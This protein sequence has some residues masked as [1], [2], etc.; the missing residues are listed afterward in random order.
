MSQTIYGT[1]MHWSNLRKP[2]LLSALFN[3]LAQGVF[4]LFIS[5]SSVDKIRG[6]ATSYSNLF[7]FAIGFMEVFV[8]GLEMD[9][10]SFIS[11]FT[12]VF[13][14]GLSIDRGFLITAVLVIMFTT[15]MVFRMRKAKGIRGF[16]RQVILRALTLIVLLVLCFSG[17]VA[18]RPNV[19]NTWQLRLSRMLDPNVQNSEN[20]P[21]IR[22]A[23]YEYS[24]RVIEQDPLKFATG[25]GFW[26]NYPIIGSRNRFSLT[27]GQT[28]DDFSTADSLWYFPFL[29][30]GVIGGSLFVAL[31][32]VVF[33]YAVK[34]L[35]R[36]HLVPANLRW[37]TCAGIAMFTVISAST[38]SGN[39]L[40]VRFWSLMFGICI[41]LMLSPTKEPAQEDRC[42]CAGFLISIRRSSF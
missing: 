13:F 42:L 41:A 26:R 22:M 19:F 28:F 2:L 30:S 27:S 33:F 17:L 21:A 15:F 31:Y 5:G 16:G 6:E 8:P 37:Q 40:Y 38:A 24:A 18:L 23:Q 32:A 34:K 12:S 20:T 1:G 7:L 39:G 36:L 35:L 4:G 14:L 10:L 11:L 9:A 29:T 3:A 25:V